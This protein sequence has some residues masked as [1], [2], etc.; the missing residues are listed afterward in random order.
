MIIDV[1]SI[2]TRRRGIACCS[3]C[4][5]G[6]LIVL[7]GSIE[8]LHGPFMWCV[9]NA[10][11]L[12]M[13]KLSCIWTPSSVDKTGQDDEQKSFLAVA[14]ETQSLRICSQ[15]EGDVTSEASTSLPTE[16]VRTRP[17]GRHNSS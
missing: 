12:P 5:L 1:M 6:I 10:F 11:K 16:G 2:L 3:L 15:L 4:S 14:I 7:S 8:K 9:A 17:P 13:D